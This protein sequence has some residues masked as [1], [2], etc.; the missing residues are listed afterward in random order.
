VNRIL[1]MVKSNSLG[2][3]TIEFLTVFVFS[4]V[5]IMLFFKISLDIANGFLVHYATFMASRTYLV[6]DINSNTPSGSDN[7]ARTRSIETFYGLLIDRLIPGWNANVQ[8]N[9][10][11]F[12]SNK[13]F[14][15]LWVEF[16]KT[17]GISKTIGGIKTIKYRSESFI[18]RE[19]TIAECVKQV[20]EAIKR[21]SGSNCNTLATLFDN[22][23]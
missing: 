16:K 10:P 5:I 3:S 8:V 2:Q 13:V 6:V 7:K 21:V 20:C 18:G 22:G 23:C 9:S 11:R 1:S 4:F 17:F 12:V 15:G 19:P 14:T